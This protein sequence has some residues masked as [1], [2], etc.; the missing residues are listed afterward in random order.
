[1]NGNEFNNGK[2]YKEKKKIKEKNRK[3]AD[4][5]NCL[6]YIAIGPVCVIFSE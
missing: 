4:L 1:M 5:K 2:K 6:G 3:G